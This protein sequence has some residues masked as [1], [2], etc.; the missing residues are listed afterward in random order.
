MVPIYWGCPNIE[1]YFDTGGMIIFNNLDELND[2]LA[3]LATDDYKH[4]SI[5]ISKNKRLA[6][7]FGSQI[8]RI[9]YSTSKDSITHGT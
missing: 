4:R 1:S 8:H 3:T 2:I 6:K 5:S 9:R 7:N